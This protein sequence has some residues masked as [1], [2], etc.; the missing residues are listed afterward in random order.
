MVN[1]SVVMGSGMEVKASVLGEALALP[2][3]SSPP[4]SAQP[5]NRLVDTRVQH[6]M[7]A[8]FAFFI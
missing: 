3:A 8:N 4:L 5:A 2:A 7:S 1:D 6:A